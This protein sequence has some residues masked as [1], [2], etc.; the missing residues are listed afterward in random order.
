M[1]APHLCRR[2]RSRRAIPRRAS[3]RARYAAGDRAS[4]GKPGGWRLRRGTPTHRPG[5]RQYPTRRGK[6]ARGGAWTPEPPCP[7]PGDPS[8]CFS[9]ASSARIRARCRHHSTCCILHRRRRRATDAA[10][11]TA[12]G[13]K[14]P[15]RC[16]LLL[17]L[18]LLLLCQPPHGLWARFPLE[19]SVES[20]RSLPPSLHTMPRCRRKLRFDSRLRGGGIA[21]CN[22]TLT[23]AA[24]RVRRVRS[25]PLNSASPPFFQRR[26]HTR[27]VS[28]VRTF[29][30]YTYTH[31]HTQSPPLPPPPSLSLFFCFFFV[32]FCLIQKSK[33]F[34]FLEVGCIRCGYHVYHTSRICTGRMCMIRRQTRHK[35]RV[36]CAYRVSV[37]ISH[38]LA[39]NQSISVSMNESRYRT[40]N[41]K[42]FFRKMLASVFPVLASGVQASVVCIRP[43]TDAYHDVLMGA[44]LYVHIWLLHECEYKTKRAHN[45]NQT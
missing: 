26:I 25:Q 2:R 5:L 19:C 8:H 20:I 27:R 43:Q 17:L 41:A 31:T 28:V 34:D 36:R 11:S 9:H 33:S 3:G 14:R 24:A 10:E 30:P 6:P 35:V 29:T 39:I 32:C 16:L 15:V 45:N 12:P 44:F 21:D 42:E 18:L 1:Q 38:K 22:E 4:R 40:A 7:V 13:R 23:A 37:C